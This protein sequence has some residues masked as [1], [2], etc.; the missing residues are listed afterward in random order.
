MTYGFILTYGFR[1]N[2]STGDLMALL[3]KTWHRRVHFFGE[4]KI[5]A[6]DISTAFDRMWHNGL[7]SK[8]KSYG[9][10]LFDSYR[11]FFIIAQFVL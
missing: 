3:T 8:V 10:V 1:K 9:V 7:I 2:R 6:S 5:V 4:S 11:I